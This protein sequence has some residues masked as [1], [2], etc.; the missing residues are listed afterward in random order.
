MVSTPQ[1]L[2]LSPPILWWV[3]LFLCS[4]FQIPLGF[5][6]IQQG[7]PALGFYLLVTFPSLIIC[8]LS[9]EGI[10]CSISQTHLMT[11]MPCLQSKNCRLKRNFKHIDSMSVHFSPYKT[12]LNFIGL[13][14]F[15]MGSSVLRCKRMHL[16]T[17]DFNFVTLL[18][19]LIG[20]CV[21]FLTTQVVQTLC[22]I[23]PEV[24]PQLFPVAKSERKSCWGE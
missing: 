11:G 24:P 4:F 16:G 8:S 10:K 21:H 6:E 5:G 1:T 17:L 9:L 15:Q 18:S 19:M 13:N 7:C 12:Q 20:S 23:L 14:G 2:A 3:V 22:N